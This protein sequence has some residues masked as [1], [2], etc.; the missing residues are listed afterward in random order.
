MNSKECDFY[1]GSL[2][3]HSKMVTFSL[4]DLN[5]YSTTGADSASIA[6]TDTNLQYY[7]DFD[8]LERNIT[9]GDMK[10]DED[11]KFSV[12]GFRL[13]LTRYYLQYILCYYIPSS[14]FVTGSW[15]SFLIP[16]DVVPGRMAMLITLLLVSVN[17]FGTII[18]I[19]PAS[20]TTLLAI[21]TL[22]CTIFITA[23]LFAYAVTLWKRWYQ[24]S[25]KGSGKNIKVAAVPQESDNKVSKG[26]EGSTISNDTNWDRNCLIAFPIAFLV[27]NMIYWPVVATQHLAAK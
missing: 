21:W 23:A 11:I 18:R 19:Q 5:M 7:F 24:D 15:I 13:I 2:W 1:V 27:F 20:R 17:L 14:V 16:P 6:A 9:S 26:N 25:N 22:A 10:F 8:R 3:H 12:V 4:K